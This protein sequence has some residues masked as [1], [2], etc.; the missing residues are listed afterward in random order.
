MIVTYNKT[1]LIPTPYILFSFFFHCIFLS[2]YI[3]IEIEKQMIPA[4]LVDA[5]E[6]MGKDSGSTLDPTR[7]F[8]YSTFTPDGQL[9]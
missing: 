1:Y 6:M 5:L 4:K 7:V 8:Y 9:L 2:M 3:Y